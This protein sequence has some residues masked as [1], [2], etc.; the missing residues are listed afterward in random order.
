LLPALL[1]VTISIIVL[2]TLVAIIIV[3]VVVV[4]VAAAL[5]VNNVCALC[6]EICH[7]CVAMPGKLQSTET[8]YKEKVMEFNNKV[9]PAF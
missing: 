9:F 5:E 4:A 2:V 3:V 6:I 7:N 8:E 1:A